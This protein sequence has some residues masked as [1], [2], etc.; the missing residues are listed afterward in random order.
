MVVGIITAIL[1]FIAGAVGVI[2]DTGKAVLDVVV[3]FF[4]SV[5]A[6]FQSFIQTAPTPM[7][8]MLFLFFILTIG[9]VFSNFALGT[10]YACDGNNVLYETDNIGTA[11]TL[12][13]KSQFQGLSVGDRNTYITQ[14]F[15]LS[16]MRPSPTYIRC[17]DA[18]PRLFFYSVNILDYKLWLLMLVIIFGAPLI[19]GYYS[20]MGALR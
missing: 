19:W 16:S 13:L 7:K 17:S 3:S 8:I 15:D 5:W 20:R 2:V 11:F 4:Q 6:I 12:I 18:K 9:N 10:R 14:N 1:T